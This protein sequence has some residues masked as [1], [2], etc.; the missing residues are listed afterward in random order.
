MQEKQKTVESHPPV[1]KR[2]AVSNF[3]AM[4]PSSA[5]SDFPDDAPSE[6][7]NLGR[8]FRQWC[9]ACAIAA[10]NCLGILLLLGLVASIPVAVAWAFALEPVQGLVGL[11]CG[12]IFLVCLLGSHLPCGSPGPFP[13]A[14][15]QDKPIEQKSVS[16]TS[17]W[18]C[19]W[20]ATL[21]A[22]GM[23]LHPLLF[24]V[25]WPWVQVWGLGPLTASV[26]GIM[27]DMRGTLIENFES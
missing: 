1:N 22:A 26:Y 2:M 4:V 13:C 27:N 23:V 17:L 24:N 9:S 12:A 10:C 25:E 3:G 19:S 18:L 8:N 21:L 7:S 15:V 16:G 20:V 11:T 6:V 14:A 5:E